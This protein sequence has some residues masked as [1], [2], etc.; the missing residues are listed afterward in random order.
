MFKVPLLLRVLLSGCASSEEE[1]HWLGSCICSPEG[2]Y[3]DGGSTEAMADCHSISFPQEDLRE[4]TLYNDGQALNKSCCNV[5][6][7]NLNSLLLTYLFILTL[8]FSPVPFSHSG[9]PSKKEKYGWF[10]MVLVLWE[11]YPWWS[12]QMRPWATW[13]Q[14]FYVWLNFS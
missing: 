5:C 1:E 8:D 3:P 14:Q 12:G 2:Q 4:E 10:S 11:F 9:I 7:M 6:K 13:K